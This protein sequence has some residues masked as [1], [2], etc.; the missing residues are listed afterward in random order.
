MI[1]DQIGMES[2]INQDELKGFIKALRYIGERL[3][4]EEKSNQ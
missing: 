3:R 4:D 1:I 2:P